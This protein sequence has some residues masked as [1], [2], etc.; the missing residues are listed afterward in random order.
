MFQQS[1]VYTMFY[2]NYVTKNYIIFLYK[3]EANKKLVVFKLN[4]NSL[5]FQIKEHLKSV[6]NKYL[7]NYSNLSENILQVVSFFLKQ[8]E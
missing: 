3:N 7:T 2:Y 4:L 6:F 5:K 8:Y 1:K